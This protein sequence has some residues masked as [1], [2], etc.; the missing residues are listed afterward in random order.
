MTDIVC[1]AALPAELPQEQFNFRF[2]LVYTG[3]G[4]LNSALATYEAIRNHNPKL[5]INV[6]TAGSLRVTQGKVVEI[7]E[8]VQRDFNAE[9]LAP[10]GII[11]YQET[12]HTIRSNYGEYICGTGDS[13]V[14]S[15]DPWFLDNK[16][17]VVDM[18]L[19]GIAYTCARM[20]IE[21]RSVKYITD[22]VGSN[23]G[24][25]WKIW[26]NK[27]PIQLINWLRENM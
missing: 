26:L 4:K 7:K 5:I 9:P 23:S 13:F 24:E 17:D 20:G 12:F 27:A 10:R 1:V 19:F 11:P 21:W 3:V 22:L 25:D 8:V 2:P 14:T 15:I 16:V 6:G 18:E